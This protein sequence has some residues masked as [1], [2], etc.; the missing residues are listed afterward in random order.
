MTHLASN[1]RKWHAASPFNLEISVAGV[2][3]ADLSDLEWVVA[4]VVAISGSAIATTDDANGEAVVTVSVGAA[5]L[6]VAALRRWQLHGSVSGRGP[7]VLSEGTLDLGE[8]YT[9]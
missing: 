9:A 8:L 1:D 2:A 5:D 3:S 4:G 7:E 6:T